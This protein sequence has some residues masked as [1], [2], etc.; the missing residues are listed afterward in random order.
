LEIQAISTYKNFKRDNL[1]LPII[2]VENYVRFDIMEKEIINQ[3][4]KENPS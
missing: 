1:N 2:F 3:R 4:T